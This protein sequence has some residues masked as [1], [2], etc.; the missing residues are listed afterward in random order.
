[1]IDFRVEASEQFLEALRLYRP[2]PPERWSM[3]RCIAIIA[4]LSA[5]SWAAILYVGS[6]LF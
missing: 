2:A 4:A 3:R 5:A 6:L 1:M